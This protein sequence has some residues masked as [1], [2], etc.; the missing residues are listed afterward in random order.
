M[1]SAFRQSVLKGVMRIILLAVVVIG[2]LVA[3]TVFEARR[4]GLRYPPTGR[5]VAIDGGRLHYTERH[6]AGA[7]RG[8][9]LLLHGASGNQADLM[10]PLGDRLAAIGFDVI[11]VDR[12]GHGWSDRPD[13]SADAAPDRQAALILQGLETMGVRH[14]IV[15]GHSWAGALAANLALDH[16]DFT[17][18]LVLLA[19]VTHRWSTGIAWYYGATSKPC[20][21]PAFAYTLTLPVGLA[22]MSSAVDEV[23]APG[24]PPS[25]FTDRTALPLVFRPRDFIANAQDVAALLPFVSKQGERMADIRA[26]T[27]IVAGEGDRIVSLDLHSRADARLIPGATL[28]ILPG[29]GHSPHWANPSAVVD[30]IRDV[31]DRSG[32]R[33]TRSAGDPIR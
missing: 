26:P 12:P 29:V 33:A 30:A 15:V 21:G 8:I 19:P 28:E 6:A 3:V 7:R 16:P 23:F 10:V 24:H 9:V 17:D 4:I 22:L 25:D 20:V 27:A 2:A 11:A 5:F 31:A 32:L 18:G 14:A 13:G 1:F